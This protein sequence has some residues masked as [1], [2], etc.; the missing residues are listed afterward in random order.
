MDKFVEIVFNAI[1]SGGVEVIG[2]LGWALF[3]L[4]RYYI[5]PRRE[6]QFREDLTKFQASYEKLGTNVTQALHGFHTI[7]EVIKDRGVR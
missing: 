5:A 4:E 3:L 7:L 1:M 6:A 2:T